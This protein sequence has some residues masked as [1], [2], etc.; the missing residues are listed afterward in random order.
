MHFKKSLT[1][2]FVVLL[3]LTFSI[4]VYFFYNKYV[5]TGTLCGGYPNGMTKCGSEE[6]FTGIHKNYLK[7]MLQEKKSFKNGI[8]HGSYK[9]YDSSGLIEKYNY[10]NGELDGK[11][12]K[13]HVDFK[14]LAQ[15]IWAQSETGHKKTIGQYKL[16]CKEGIWN[17]YNLDQI[18]E[19]ISK[20][21]QYQNCLLH[22][23]Q[24]DYFT[25][26]GMKVYGNQHFMLKVSK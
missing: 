2:V 8:L 10:R 16:G 6:P 17:T 24:I 25:F 12:I 7:G 19:P 22:G 14:Y 5:Y 11:F 3:I 23:E 26:L 21:R 9:K 15:N 1:Y 13:K 4:F 18:S 20:K